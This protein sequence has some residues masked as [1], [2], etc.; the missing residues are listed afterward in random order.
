MKRNF[1]IEAID[2]SE[3][4]HLF[5]LS[6]EKLAEI[7]AV[8]MIV[9]NK[10]VYPCRVSLQDAEIGEEVILFP[11][12]HHE[13][14]SPYQSSGPIFVRKN[15]ETARL[16]VN[17]IPLMLNHRLLSIRAYDKNSVIVEA[18]VIKGKIFADTIDD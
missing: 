11:Y 1:Q 17:E 9:D 13:V 18:E 14:K 5:Q 2:Y 6:D 15:A 16:K 10:P 12:K 8:R 4:K 3:V 7:N